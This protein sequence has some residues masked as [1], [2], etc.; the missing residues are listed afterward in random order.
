MVLEEFDTDEKIDIVQNYIRTS[1]PKI[2]ESIELRSGEKLEDFEKSYLFS[3]RHVSDTE[4]FTFVHGERVVIKNI[5]MHVKSEK[6]KTQNRFN[7][8]TSETK[9]AQ[10]NLI[11][12]AVG[13]IFGED[14]QL[15]ISK[16]NDKKHIEEAT[17]INSK[18]RLLISIEKINNQY[19][20]VR[21]LIEVI[22]LFENN[23]TIDVNDKG[24]LRA[25]VQCVFCTKFLKVSKKQSSC[26]WVLSN[27]KRHIQNS[28]GAT[29]NAET[30]LDNHLVDRDM[31]AEPNVSKNNETKS[32][33][34]HLEIQPVMQN[35]DDLDNKSND[36]FTSCVE[37]LKTQLK[38]Q[39]IKMINSVISNGETQ[40]TCEIQINLRVSQ[41]EVSEMVPDGNCLFSAISHQ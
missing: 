20:T 18:Q 17:V 32:S 9:F 25:R 28:C 4:N 26:T 35:I 24:N 22:E 19:K 27:L 30:E 41:I 23:I 10:N 5:S 16:E 31:E 12:T 21:G 2:V 13:L 36:E 3:D 33:L 7:L 38:L 11:Q 34:L 6:V 29:T 14:Q 40:K 15:K 8:T 1:L 39:R 37:R